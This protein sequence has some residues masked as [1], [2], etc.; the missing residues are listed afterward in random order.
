METIVLVNKQW[1]SFSKYSYFIRNI[2]SSIG[3]IRI[4]INC[5]LMVDKDFILDYSA[6][7]RKFK[8]ND[9]KH[10]WKWIIEHQ[11]FDFC[12]RHLYE[13]DYGLSQSTFQL[14]DKLANT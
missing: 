6:P 12:F 9:L 2:L 10:G 5:L 7:L 13:L 11:I 3:S 8:T 4:I 1:G 14:L